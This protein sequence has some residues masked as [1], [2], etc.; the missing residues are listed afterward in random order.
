MWEES[1][2]NEMICPMCNKV[3]SDEEPTYSSW[4]CSSCG[5]SWQRDNPFIKYDNLSGTSGTRDL[6]PGRNNSGLSDD[7][8]GDKWKEEFNQRFAQK[9]EMLKAEALKKKAEKAEAL[10]KEAEAEPLKPWQREPNELRFRHCELNCLIRRSSLGFLC[11]YVL[12]PS[13]HPFF[14]KDRFDD[15]EVHGGITFADEIDGWWQVGFDCGHGWD[16]APA[17]PVSTSNKDNYKTIEYVRKET[18][19]L[20][21][22]IAEK[23]KNVFYRPGNRRI[24]L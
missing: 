14:R 22:Q 5:C 16:Y 1:P 10:K 2:M 18:E 3:T 8:Y 15:V 21:K 24:D 12:L 17:S 6:F 4:Q 19:K 11:G 13:E 7:E 20:A 23:A 9:F